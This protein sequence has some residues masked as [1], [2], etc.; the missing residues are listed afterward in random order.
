MCLAPKAQHQ[1][2]AWGSA[3]GYMRTKFISAE[4]AIQFRTSSMQCPI[5]TRFQRLLRGNLNSWG[6]APS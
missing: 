3:P 4:S 1:S 2:Q 6:D 5:E